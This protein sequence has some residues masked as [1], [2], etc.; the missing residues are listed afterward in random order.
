VRDSIAKE[1]QRHVSKQAVKTSR[2]KGDFPRT[3]MAL[4][5]RCVDL[6]MGDMDLRSCSSGVKWRATHAGVLVTQGPTPLSTSFGPTTVSSS[7]ELRSFFGWGSSSFV[8][9]SV[10]ESQFVQNS[11]A[12][13]ITVWRGGVC[14]S[15]RHDAK[16]EGAQQCYR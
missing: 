16:S 4:V 15:M 9:W 1:W 2:K 10:L 12:R 3:C 6:V 11:L 13:V 7:V 5:M 14:K 8:L